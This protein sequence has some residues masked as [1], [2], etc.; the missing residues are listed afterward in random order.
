MAFNLVSQK[1]SPRF[2]EF[3]Q[4]LFE[5]IHEFVISYKHR[6]AS[7]LVVVRQIFFTGVQA[8]WIVSLIAFVIGSTILLQGNSIISTFSQ[9]KIFYTILVSMVVKE[10]GALLTAIIVVARSG[11]AISTELGNMVV[12]KE[13]D[14]LLSFGITPISYL[15]VPR[16]IGVVISVSFLTVYFIFTALFGVW[17]LS[18]F[19]TPI[20]LSLFIQN[21]ALEIRFLDVILLVIKTIVFGIIIS[22][23][24]CFQG[25][26]VTLATTEVPQ[27]TIKTVVRSFSWIVVFNILVTIVFYLL[28]E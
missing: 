21:I 28:V 17:F 2:I 18:L 22:T 19:F 10:L 15:V 16:I 13:I 26:S 14:A 6:K 24:S 7:Y 12:N 4:F 23:I 3:I 11:T 1:I 20:N 9:S 5:V 27:R 25:L 8:L